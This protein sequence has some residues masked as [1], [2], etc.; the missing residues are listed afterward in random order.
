[1]PQ[2]LVGMVDTSSLGLE[3]P[4]SKDLF[5]ELL[6]DFA[7]SRR[8]QKK[9]RGQIVLDYVQKNCDIPSSERFKR[10]SISQARTA[11]K[12]V[13]DGESGTVTENGKFRVSPA[14]RAPREKSGKVIGKGKAKTKGR[15]QKD[16]GSVSDTESE[17]D[18]GYGS[19][20]P[21]SSRTSSVSNKGIRG[22]SKLRNVTKT[23]SAESPGARRS[24]PR[25][26]KS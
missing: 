11:A 21:R 13:L 9:L 20:S 25:L 15:K 24:S 18:D 4:R 7:Q 26:R 19:G 1:M 3:K 16:S 17:N 5:T 22:K 2:S 14:P 6:G 23:S 8:I 12:A 10:L